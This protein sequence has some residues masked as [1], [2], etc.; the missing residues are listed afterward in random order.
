MTT[1]D[2]SRTH[3]FPPTGCVNQW[4]ADHDHADCWAA[5][6]A[7][8]EAPAGLGIDEFYRWLETTPHAADITPDG[9]GFLVTCRR[10]CALGTSARQGDRAGADRRVRQHRICTIPLTA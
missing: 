4:A 2:T 6:L 7:F 10:G 3:R 9:D 8:H 1:P 5:F